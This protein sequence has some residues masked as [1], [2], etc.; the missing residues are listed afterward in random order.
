MQD[1]PFVKEAET[2]GTKMLKKV[3]NTNTR[4]IMSSQKQHSKVK[5]LITTFDISSNLIICFSLGS[6]WQFTR[7]E[8]EAE[9]KDGR[10]TKR[11]KTKG[12]VMFE[13][14]YSAQP[15]TLRYSDIFQQL[16]SLS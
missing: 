2:P 16:S 10:T 8:H 9:A 14:T 13:V 3:E 1:S 4:I 7:R 6:T 15:V 12:T 5:T 11:R